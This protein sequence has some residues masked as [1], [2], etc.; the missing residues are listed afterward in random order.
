MTVE[1]EQ[2]VDRPAAHPVLRAVRRAL[3]VTFVEPVAN[4]RPIPSRWP[5]GLGVV[6]WTTGALIVVLAAVS[7]FARVL[8]AHFP[9]VSSQV[10]NRS[11]PEIL[12]PLFVAVVIWTL[13]LAHCAL[14]RL[15]WYIKLPALGVT[16]SAMV[17]LGVFSNGRLLVIALAALSYLAVV[18]IVFA[19]RRASYVWWEFPLV[20]TLVAISWLV[21]LLAP[22]FD[23]QVVVDLR[24]VSVEAALESFSSV[25]M[26]ALIAAG[27]APALITVSA[28]EAVAA[29]PLPRVL[30]ILG[31]LAVVVWR[32]V[33]TIQTVR[34]DPVEQGLEA[35]LAS[36]MTLG[37]TA[38]ALILVWRLSPRRD[39]ERPG[40]LPELWTAWSFP[41]AVALVGVVALTVPVTTAYYFWITFHLPGE[42]VM[43][44]LFGG[45]QALSSTWWR[46]IPGT[47]FGIGAVILARRGRVGEA[48]LLAAVCV[49]AVSGAVATVLP[50]AMLRARTPD[51]IAAIT[52]W[53]AIVVLAITALMRR[54]TRRR[55][56]GLLTVLLVGGLYTYRNAL[57]DP[58]SAV[59]GFA[60]LGIALFGLVWQALT[61]AAFTRSGS[62]RFPE[63][64]RILAYL[65]NTL[66]A[67]GVVA[68]VSV[69]RVEVGS[70]S[71]SD[72]NATGDA[73]LG[74]PL[75]LAATVLGLW[76]G[77]G[78]EEADEKAES[79]AGAPA[80]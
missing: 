18:V 55:L 16:L 48:S 24:L 45:V 78:A 44:W 65:A 53:L 68:F 46:A 34:G 61:G 4:G 3:E 69:S 42:S 14:I 76:Y 19:R 32:V 54:L 58:V 37:L 71:L 20:T 9:F 80:R 49:V 63:P 29:R 28:A 21:V 10:S 47:A 17:S 12:L 50:P 13:G 6:G 43:V 7:G 27:V 15:A 30:T 41:V 66:F 2:I 23:T 36:V 38:L 33:T 22:A 25:A 74:T 1:V 62:R 39:V 35:L 26:P 52:S 64:T 31:V 40:N 5:A 77:F 60:G 56:V 57:D 51:A 59:F 79:F 70:V 72:L 73:A 67:F 8:R 11:M 75:L